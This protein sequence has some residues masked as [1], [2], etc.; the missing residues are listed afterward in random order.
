MKPMKQQIKSFY[1]KTIVGL[2]V[3][4]TRRIMGGVRMEIINTG[5][6]ITVIPTPTE[7]T[8]YLQAEIIET[9]GG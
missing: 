4:Q 8:D 9:G 2:N 1:G 5:N 6:N 7:D 3:E